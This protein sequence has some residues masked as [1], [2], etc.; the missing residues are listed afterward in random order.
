MRRSVVPYV[1]QGG[2]M[3]ARGTSG[4]PPCRLHG[5]DMGF[6]QGH[7]AACSQVT[8]LSPAV[9]ACVAIYLSIVSLFPLHDRFPLSYLLQVLN[10]PRALVTSRFGG[11]VIVMWCDVPFSA[12][13]RSGRVWV[14]YK[15][16]DHF[17]VT[18]CCVPL[19]AER[20]QCC[21]G[22]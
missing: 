2:G 9:F 8:L 12:P 4:S 14:P 1:T 6:Y 18:I 21:I 20:C 5:L 7:T 13:R 15:H 22:T 19:L 17:L 3:L 11:D 16:A 10:Q